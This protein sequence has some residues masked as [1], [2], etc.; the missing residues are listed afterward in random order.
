MG[1][2]DHM[3]KRSYLTRSPYYPWEERQNLEGMSEATVHG[4]KRLHII[5]DNIML[6]MNVWIPDQSMW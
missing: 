3:Q 2:K 5:E 4:A 1:P 6:V